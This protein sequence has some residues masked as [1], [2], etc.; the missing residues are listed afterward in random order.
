MTESFVSE[1]YWRR[2]AFFPLMFDARMLSTV[3]PLILL[4][5]FRGMGTLVSLVIV[6]V[7]LLATNVVVY[8]GMCFR[9]YDDK[10]V[11]RRGIMRRNLTTVPFSEVHDVDF[12]QNPVQRLFK[13]GV[14]QFQTSSSDGITASLPCIRLTEIDEIREIYACYKLQE[15]TLA[16]QADQ[17]SQ[18]AEDYG[19]DH[20]VAGLTFKE[21]LLLCLIRSPLV[22]FL[23]MA[24]VV[25][26]AGYSTISDFVFKHVDEQFLREF[27][28]LTFSA[29]FPWIHVEVFDYEQFFIVTSLVFSAIFMLVLFV[30]TS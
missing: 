17:P 2:A 10:V 29:T 25:L 14:L 16:T 22:W 19:G 18:A 1:P 6:V 28:S 13:V 9:I 8:F 15:Q 11:I 21:N 24:M 30:L 27:G 7:G 12:V 4:A 5:A 3:L 26:G 23:S 20:V